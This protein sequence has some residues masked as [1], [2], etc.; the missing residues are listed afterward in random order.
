MWTI[1]STFLPEAT[2]S[3]IDYARKNTSIMSEEN[4]DDLIEVDNQIFQMLKM[5]FSQKLNK[6]IVNILSILH[7]GRTPFLLKKSTKLNRSRATQ[8]TYT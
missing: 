1:I 7:S 3:I 5:V 6:P 2:K 4:K 8:K